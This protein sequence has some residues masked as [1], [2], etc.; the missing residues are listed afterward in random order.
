[1]ESNIEIIK[2]SFIKLIEATDYEKV[3]IS[4]I[5]RAAGISRR[6]FYRYFGGI[7]QIVTMLVRDD[8]IEP[9]IQIRSILPIDE[10][11]S[12]QILMLERIYAVIYEKRVLYEKLLDYRGKRSLAEVIT[13]ESYTLHLKIYSSFIP[14]KSELEYASFFT[15]VSQAMIIDRW[16][17]NEMV[18]PPKQI[19]KYASMWVFAHFRELASN[20]ERIDKGR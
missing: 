15:A 11:K 14:D 8:F 7:E 1:M 17:R 18:I 20:S 19:A 6:T 9:V 10:I 2:A 3:T 12:A 4:S 16:I 5:C 13:E